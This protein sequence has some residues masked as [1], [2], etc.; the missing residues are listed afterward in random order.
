MR[1][2]GGL[3]PHSRGDDGGVHMGDGPRGIQP[4][5]FTDGTLPVNS[6]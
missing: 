6:L 5:T 1:V 2:V 4:A 3:P